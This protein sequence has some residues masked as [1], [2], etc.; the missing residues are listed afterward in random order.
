MLDYSTDNG[1]SWISIDPNTPNNGEFE[2]NSIPAENSNQCFVRICDVNN[3]SMCDIGDD[4]FIIFKCLET[5]TTDM[6]GNCFIDEI[7][8]VL[9]AEQWLQGGNPLDSN[10]LP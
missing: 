3:P 2:W 6:D 4:T 5:L 7:D 10:W 1:S 8:V 9:F